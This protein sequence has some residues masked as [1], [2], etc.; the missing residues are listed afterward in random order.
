MHDRGLTYQIYIYLPES[1][2]PLLEQK[3]NKNLLILNDS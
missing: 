3:S 1:N 2:K